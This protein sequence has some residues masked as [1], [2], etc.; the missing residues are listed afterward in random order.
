M[1]NEITTPF[2]A[3]SDLTRITA[4]TRGGV[5]PDSSDTG[6]NG[7]DQAMDNSRISQ[8][9]LAYLFFTVLFPPWYSTIHKSL[10]GLPTDA[11]M[12][13]L[14]ASVWGM[15]VVVVIVALGRMF[16]DKTLTGYIPHP[17]TRQTS[18]WSE[19]AGYDMVSSSVPL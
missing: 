15:L 16:P 19:P 3:G 9:Q 1:A 13:A 7:G 14:L 11:W 5:E 2:I 6:G 12:T 18:G 8:R 17:D 10:W 4:T